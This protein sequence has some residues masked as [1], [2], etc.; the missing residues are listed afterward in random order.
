MSFKFTAFLASV[1]IAMQNAGGL[2]LR[3]APATAQAS[4]ASTPKV[5]SEGVAEPG[6]CAGCGGEHVELD[7]DA[8]ASAGA[9]SPNPDA[10]V[11]SSTVRD[12][13]R[14][15]ICQRPFSFLRKQLVMVPCGCRTCNTS[16][17]QLSAKR[18]VKEFIREKYQDEKNK[19]P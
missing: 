12:C 8:S 5:D 19:N 3:R 14:C 9:S 7:P 10:A 11:L 15:S 16:K 6:V 17:L 13:N 2:Q 18:V 1:V 4:Q